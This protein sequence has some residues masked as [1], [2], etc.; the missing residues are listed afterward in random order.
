MSSALPRCRSLET[1][2]GARSKESGDGTE[3]VFQGQNAAFGVARDASA[4][5][6]KSAPKKRDATVTVYCP[7]LQRPRLIPDSTGRG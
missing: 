5:T 1:P 4:R 6:R 3:R 7:Q 2:N